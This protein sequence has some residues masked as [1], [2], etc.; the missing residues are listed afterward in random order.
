MAEASAR[1]T[2]G[3]RDVL[4][5]GVAP[6]TQTAPPDRPGTTVKGAPV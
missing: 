6:D 1:A 3:S 4:Y 5:R 2:L